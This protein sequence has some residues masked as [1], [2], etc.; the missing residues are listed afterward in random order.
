MDE[1]V[2]HGPSNY[3]WKRN[4]VGEPVAWSKR[5]GRYRRI[6]PNQQEADEILAG[7]EPA[8]Y[9]YA[10]QDPAF[11]D[12]TKEGFGGSEEWPFDA[13]KCALDDGYRSGV[14]N[15]MLAVWVAPNW[16]RAAQKGLDRVWRVR[17]RA[18][19]VAAKCRISFQDALIE[20]I[21]YNFF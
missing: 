15:A 13:R 21:N 17:R 16:A 4:Y 6:V 18:A 14:Y 3:R 10:D 20:Q 7:N 9:S 19:S 12:P 11:Q 5:E 2:R 1:G 8:F